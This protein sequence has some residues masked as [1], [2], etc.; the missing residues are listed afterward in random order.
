MFPRGQTGSNGVKLWLSQF[1]Q[2]WIGPK[3]WKRHQSIQ[4][5]RDGFGLPDCVVYIEHVVINEN[6]PPW[7]T[8][9]EATV[10]R[11]ACARGSC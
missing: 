7:C 1:I 8:L 6:G 11:E 2:R 3:I 5:S 10:V 9:A 4:Q